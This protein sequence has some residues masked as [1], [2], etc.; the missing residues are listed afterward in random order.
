MLLSCIMGNV[1][2]SV[3]VGLTCTLYLHVSCLFRAKLLEWPFKSFTNFNATKRET[4]KHK[5]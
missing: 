1:G 3:F 5:D 4:I 2:S